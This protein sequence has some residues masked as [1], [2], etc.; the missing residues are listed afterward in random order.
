MGNEH[1][2]FRDGEIVL[3][4]QIHCEGCSSK[5]FNCLKDFQ[6]VEGVEVDMKG[7]RVMVK[8][9]KADPFKVLE[10]VKKKYSRNVQLIFPKPKSKDGDKVDS[11]SKQEPKISVVA[12]KTYMH[13]EGCVNDIKRRIERIQGVLNVEM[14]TENSTV[15]VKGEFDPTELVGTVGKR[16]GKYVEIVESNQEGNGSKKKGKGEEIIFHYPPR[17]LAEH[18]Y[19]T[20][21]FSDVNISSCSVM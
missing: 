20:Q 19:P 11:Q 14:D 12:L 9:Q 7:K 8:G 13:C 6:G 16:L 2:Q 5:V 18:V 4:V 17:Y 10:R 21:I 15:T 3:K 1:H